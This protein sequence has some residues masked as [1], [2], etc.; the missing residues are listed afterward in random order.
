MTRKTAEKP[1]R[2]AESCAHC[3]ETSGRIEHGGYY[4]GRPVCDAC[5]EYAESHGGASRPVRFKV[6]KPARVIGK[7]E[8]LT[9]R[10]VMVRLRMSKNAIYE[11]LERGEIPSVRIGRAYRIPAAWLDLKARRGGV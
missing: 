4:C 9:V 8:F 3:G 11:A 5:N 7:P 6:R 1:A 10:E 2:E